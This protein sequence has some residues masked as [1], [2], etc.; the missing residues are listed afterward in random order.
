FDTRSSWKIL[1]LHKA[2]CPIC[3]SEWSANSQIIYE[4]LLWALEL[5]KICPVH[6]KK[7]ITY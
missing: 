6:H 3:Y 1:R 4:P 2:W 7:L 5:V